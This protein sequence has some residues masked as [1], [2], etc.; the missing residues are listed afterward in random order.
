MIRL[1]YL[2]RLWKE[3]EIRLEDLKHQIDDIQKKLLSIKRLWPFEQ[4]ET[5]FVLYKN[6]KQHFVIIEPELLHL[7]DKIPVLCKELNVIS[8]Q[9]DITYDVE[10][11]FDNIADIYS[12]TT[13]LIKHLTT[14]NLYDLQLV[15]EIFKNFHQK[16]TS[17]KGMRVDVLNHQ[18]IIAI[19][20]ESF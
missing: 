11:R 18:M 8:L 17:I 19:P 7:N 15:E 14:Y 5:V 6:F 13:T 10:K 2:L 3:Y 20:N 4:I 16:S 1:E 12:N 9:N